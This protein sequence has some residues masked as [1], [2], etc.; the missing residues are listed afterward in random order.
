MR[1]PCAAI[2]AKDCWDQLT[3]FEKEKF[4]PLCPDFVIEL[5]SPSDRLPPLKEKMLEW[6]ANG[7]RL[8]WLIDRK[9]EQVHIYRTDGSIEIVKSFSEKLSGE[10][11][12]P[13]FELALQLL[14]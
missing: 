7:C 1:A 2:V 4:P 10:D 8:A 14:K 12:V 3:V 9:E 5:R 11:V 13:G 6:I